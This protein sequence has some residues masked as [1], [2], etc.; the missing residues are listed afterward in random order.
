VLEAKDYMRGHGIPMRL[1]PAA[2]GVVV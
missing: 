2:A 1:D